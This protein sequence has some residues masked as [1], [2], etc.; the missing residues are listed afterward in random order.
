MQD[1]AIGTIAVKKIH[2]RKLQITCL[3]R[4]H[5][6]NLLNTLDNDN[7][8]LSARGFEKYYAT[9]V[10]EGKK[11]SSR[12]FG[13][14]SSALSFQAGIDDASSPCPFAHVQSGYF[15]ALPCGCISDSEK[16]GGEKI[17]NGSLAV[18]IFHDVI[19]L[20]SVARRFFAKITPGSFRTAARK[21]I[22]QFAGTVR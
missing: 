21:G 20:S 8:R 11:N 13:R 9:A 5:C 14:R 10:T 4:C 6:A 3:P 18:G 16:G 12:K 17:L 15:A 19:F 1:K 7:D 22:V 2:R